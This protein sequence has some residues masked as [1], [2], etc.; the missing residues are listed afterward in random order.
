MKVLK[1]L[2]KS[3]ILLALPIWLTFNYS[4]FIPS[5]SYTSF[6]IKDL[7]KAGQDQNNC[8]QINNKIKNF[9]NAVDKIK[10]KEKEF[11]SILGVP[12][13]LFGYNLH[14]K[15]NSKAITRDNKNVEIIFR[16]DI[17]NNYKEINFGEDKKISTFSNFNNIKMDYS[18]KYF[19]EDGKECPEDTEISIN[20]NNNTI[21]FY[22]KPTLGGYLIVFLFGLTFAYGILLL[23]ANCYKFIFW[24]K[25]FIKD[26]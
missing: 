23:I 8:L 5:F 21:D 1:I 7:A 25:P 17:S 12:G 19:F 2:V 16:I 6:S 15:N 11:G 26:N 4:S 20:E 22:L 10:E 13:N 3:I 24:G 14:F 18:F 9:L